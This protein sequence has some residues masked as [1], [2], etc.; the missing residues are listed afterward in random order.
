MGILVYLRLGIGTNNKTCFGP[1]K[2]QLSV[3][4]WLRSGPVMAHVWPLSLIHF[5]A[6]ILC[7]IWAERKVFAWPGAGPENICYVG[8]SGCKKRV[9]AVKIPISSIRAIIKHFQSTKDVT[10]L[11]GRGRVSVS[12]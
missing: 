5:R 6:V 7:G 12:S 9:K 11:P 1:V 4:N 8:E 10:K 3:I 2:G